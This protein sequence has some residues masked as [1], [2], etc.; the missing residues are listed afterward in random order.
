MAF[1]KVAALDLDGTLTSAGRI[2][3]ETLDAIDQARRGGLVV[4]LVTGRIGEELKADFPDIADHVDALVLENGAVTVTHG[5][6]HLLSAP[7][8]DGLDAALAHRDVPYRRG[9]VLLAIDGEHAITVLELIG[10]LGLDCQLVRNRGALMVLPAD[11]TKGSGLSA[12]L[13]EL[14]LSVHN[15]LA[16]GDA[17]NDLSMFKVAEIGAAVANAVPAVQRNADLVLVHDDGAG[18]ANLLT[19][20]YLNGAR[21]WCPLRRW[22]D[23]G[24]YDDGTPAQI[25]GSQARVLVTGPAGSGKSYLVGLLAERWIT[26]GYCVLVIDPEGDHVELEDLGRVQVIDARRYLPEPT[27]LVNSLVRPGSSIVVDMSAIA[28]ADKTDFVHL[29]RATAEAHREQ[30]GFPHWVIYD[31]AHLLGADPNARWVRRGG[32]LLSSFTPAALPAEEIDSTDVVLGLPGRDT[33]SHVGSRI[34][35]RATI[36]FGFGEVRPFTI[37]E[38]QTAHVRHRHKYADV[39]L[40]RERRFYFQASVGRPPAPAGTM[41]EFVT[42][43]TQLDPLALQRHLEQGDFSRWLAG[44][45]ADKNLAAQVA[46]WEDELPAHRAADVERSTN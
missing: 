42:A 29:L 27:E 24:T 28:A 37:A 2:S 22:I 12:V 34:R 46:G 33:S 13:T 16:V 26:S 11:V 41:H 39:S 14:N 20:P 6:A 15:T 18:L 43:L 38:R 30:H 36:R 32:Y 19:G 31:E 3:P 5:K 44:T 8:D 9:E 17:E 21:R 4:V 23:I 1:I 7:V 10:Q 25:P 35:R 45:I 40:P